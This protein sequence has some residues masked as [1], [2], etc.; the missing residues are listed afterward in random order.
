MSKFSTRIPVDLKTLLS[1]LPKGCYIDRMVFSHVIDDRNRM[2]M[3]DKINSGKLVPEVIL[4]WEDDRLQSET[5]LATDFSVSDLKAKT[6]PKN[7]R[8]VVKN[9]IPKEKPKAA[10][11][12]PKP[13]VPPIKMDLLTEKQVAECV[14]KGE[15]VE[16]Q[17]YEP[18]WKAFDPKEHQFNKVFFYRKKLEVHA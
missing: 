2:E 1:L 16:F 7:V 12:E 5:T 10:D 9:P 17:G 8:D 14:S 4:Y 13:I 18:F 3:V 6:L 15:P 11:P